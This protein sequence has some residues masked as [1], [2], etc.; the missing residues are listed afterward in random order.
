MDVRV[1][2]VSVGGS[3]DISI[4][5]FGFSCPSLSVTRLTSEMVVTASRCVVTLLAPDPFSGEIIK[6]LVSVEYRLTKLAD[7]QIN[8]STRWTDLSP[9]SPEAERV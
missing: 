5:G 2:I 1:P 9:I 6:L 3:I 4:D 8:E 7:T